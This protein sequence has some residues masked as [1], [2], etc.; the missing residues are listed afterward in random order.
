MFSSILKS[1][2]LEKLL[3]SESVRDRICKM[4]EVAISKNMENFDIVSIKVFNE[5]VYVFGAMFNRDH[6]VRMNAK[7]F[8]DIGLPIDI[9]PVISK[10]LANSGIMDGT[11]IFTKNNDLIMMTTMDD[12]FGVTIIGELKAKMNDFILENIDSIS[13]VAKT[14]G[15]V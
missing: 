4:V 13:N 7:D 2:P 12:S 1:M 14:E 10:M 9:F 6:K 11:F 5:K 8:F 3:K 15:I